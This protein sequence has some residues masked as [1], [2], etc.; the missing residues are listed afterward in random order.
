[1]FEKSTAAAGYAPEE[2]AQRCE[3]SPEQAHRYYR[4]FRS[5]RAELDRLLAATDRT[6]R[7][8]DD[9]IERTVLEVTFG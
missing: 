6:P 7:H 1:M 2:L 9:E 4:R 5:R 8:R 3:I